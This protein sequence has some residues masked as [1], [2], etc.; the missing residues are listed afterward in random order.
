MEGGFELHL[1]SGDTT[2]CRCWQVTRRDGTIHGFTDHDR[3]LVIDGVR[4]RA[5]TGLSAGML[6]SSTGLSVDNSEALGALTDTAITAADIEAGRYDGAEVTALLV[7]WTDTK[8]RQIQ[9]RGTIGEVR[10]SG[11]AFQAELRGLTE[12]LNR[13]VGRIYQAACPSVL[14]DA[15]CGVDVDAPAFSAEARV[16]ETVARSQFTLEGADEFSPGWFTRG[17]FEVLGGAAYGLTGMI[18]ADDV[19]TGGRAVRLWQP[20][21]APVEVGTRVRLV[22]GC[23]KR[24][25]TCR[26]KFAN[27]LNFGGFP[28]IPGDDWLMSYPG[29]GTMDGGPLIP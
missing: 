9:F 1:E 8:Q 23:D 28:H 2:V 3:D 4:F 7:N 6:Q 27:F 11:G 10:R 25:E 12:A 22:A 16:V 14:G 15:A 19:G 21:A 24:A 18:K 13:P 17:R 20:I 29:N 5:D 26:A